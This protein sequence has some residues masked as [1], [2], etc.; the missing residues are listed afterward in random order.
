MNAADH[1]I[2]YAN[3]SVVQKAV[4][5][6][7]RPVQNCSNMYEGG[8]RGCSSGPNTFMTIWHIID[9][10]HGICQQ[11]DMK[12][13]EFEVLLNDLPENDFNY[14]FKSV[15]SFII[16]RLKKETGDM[17]QERC[18]IRGVAGSFYHRL[19]PAKSLHFVYSSYALHWLS[20]VPVGVENNKGNICMAGSSPS[21]VVEAYAQQFQKDFINFLSLRSK[22]ILPQGRMVLTFTARKNQNPSNEDYGLELGVVKEADVDSFNIPL[23]A[24]CKEEVAE[25]VEREGSFE[26]K[27]LQVFVVDTD[28]QNR[29]DKKDLDFN[30][31]TQMGKN[32]ANTMRAVL[33][34]ILHFGDVILDELFKRFATNAA[35]PLRSSMLQKKVNIVVS[36]WQRNYCNKK[37]SLNKYARELHLH[38]WL[39]RIGKRINDGI[40]LTARRIRGNIYMARSSPPCFEAY[41]KCQPISKGLQF[42]KHALQGRMVLTFKARKNQNPFSEDYGAGLEP[43]FYCHLGGAIIDE[44]FKRFAAHVAYAP[45]NSCIRWGWKRGQKEAKVLRMNAADH[46][47][48]YANNSVVQKAVISKVRS[49]VEES[50]TDMF[51]KTV[52]TCMKVADLGCSSGPN[53]FMTIWHIINTIHGICQQEDMKLPEFEVLLNDLPENDFNYVFKSVPSF[54]ETQKKE[55]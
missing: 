5:S 15:S 36:S 33:E 48:S 9:T 35:D 42:S 22:E 40:P 50:I 12:L 3:N 18:F 25:I 46:E 6:K 23:Y 26:I 17:V 21:N 2:S 13:P 41:A 55:T 54:I 43:I 8:R 39:S 28:P 10:I 14:V 51:S 44:L 30:F 29:D 38:D 20:K 45:N 34:S 53:T 27:E 19:F 37:I 49:M 47:I 7:V 11:E 31:C 1:E 4:I 16:E 32:Y 24:P 52:A